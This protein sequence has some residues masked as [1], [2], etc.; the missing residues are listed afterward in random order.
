MAQTAAF[1]IIF[2]VIALLILLCTDWGCGDSDGFTDNWLD[3]KGD[4]E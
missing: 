2:G 3:T 4:D 1:L